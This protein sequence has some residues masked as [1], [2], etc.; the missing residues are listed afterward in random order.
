MV[1]L[2]LWVFS[3]FFGGSRPAAPQYWC[4]PLASPV[5]GGCCRTGGWFF[6]WGGGDLLVSYGSLFD[7]LSAVYSLAAPIYHLLRIGAL[8]VGWEGCSRVFLYSVWFVLIPVGDMRWRRWWRI[9]GAELWG[10]PE[11]SARE[12]A[13]VEVFGLAG[14]LVFSSALFRHVESFANQYCYGGE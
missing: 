4:W 5:Y 6:C 10:G 9:V 11:V 12:V 13:T 2:K 3:C 7:M 8:C 1:F 14:L